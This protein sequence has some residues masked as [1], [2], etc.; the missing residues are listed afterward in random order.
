[1]R[2]RLVRAI[3][4]RSMMDGTVDDAMHGAGSS[5]H[6]GESLAVSSKK[7]EHVQWQTPLRLVVPAGNI[8][9]PSRYK[10]GELA[11]RKERRLGVQCSEGQA[12][13]SIPLAPPLSRIPQASPPSFDVVRAIEAGFVPNV[14][15]R[16]LWSRLSESD[17]QSF[18]AEFPVL[19]AY[20]IEPEAVPAILLHQNFRHPTCGKQC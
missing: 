19:Y 17:R 11:L 6:A 8:V 13:S 2:K 1:M 15:V 18:R 10:G 3:S 9:D 12:T 5:E 4:E 16:N 7:F 20:C 14:L